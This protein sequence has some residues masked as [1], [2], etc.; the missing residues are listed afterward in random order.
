MI[1]RRRNRVSP[2]DRAPGVIYFTQIAGISAAGWSA[3]ASLTVCAAILQPGTAVETVANVSAFSPWP[4]PAGPGEDASSVPYLMWANVDEVHLAVAQ[5]DLGTRLLQMLGHVVSR[6]PVITIGV[7]VTI[8]CERIIR[9]APFASRL[10]RLSWIGAAVFAITGFAGQSLSDLASFRL[11]EIAFDL[12]RADSPAAEP[13]TPIWPAS[14][15]LWPLW[16]ALALAVL[17][18][19]IR[20]GARLERETEGLI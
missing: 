1:L 2:P 12:I 7:F 5:T 13:P 8:L 10:I 20:H 14:L 11:A 17:A 19:L 15:D 4:V 6:V 16:G 18:V 3:I 9:H